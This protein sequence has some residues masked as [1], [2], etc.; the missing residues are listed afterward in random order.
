[1]TTAKLRLVVFTGGPLAP[2]NRVF[3]E[4]LA[5]DPLFDLAAIV[6]DEYRRPLKPLL[7]RIERA[8][9]EDGPAWLAFKLGS[10]LRS[11]SDRATLRIAALA[12]GRPHSEESY[13]T[14]E[15][16]TGV[17]IHRVADIHDAESLELIRSLS[18]K[19]GVIVGGRILRDSV[20]TIP[21]HGTLNIH[22]RKVPDYR[23]GGPVGY[24]ELLAGERFIGVTIHYA[25]T[26]V[27]AGPVLA[28]VTIPIEE[29]DTLESLQLKAD[30]RGA[31]LYHETLRRFAE[32]YREGVPQ[33]LSRGTTYRAPSEFKVWQLRRR[34]ERR[35][36]RTMEVLRAR[37]SRLVRMRVLAQYAVVLPRL[38]AVRRRLVREQRAPINILFYHLV[39]DRPLNHMSLPLPV[40]VRQM[41][42]LWRYYTVLSLDEA[43]ER[44]RSG[45]NDQI[46]ASITF[47]DGYRD[48]A[49]AIEYLRYFG[50]P[51]TFFV[52]IGH[53]RDGSVFE[54][55]RQKGFEEARP[56]SEDDLRSLAGDG[57]VIGSHGVHHE[58]FGSLEPATAEQILRES[59][60]LIQEICGKAP[61]HFSFPKGQR[62]TNIT[63]ASFA[64][65]L[66]YFPYVYSAYSGYCF[67]QNG[68]RHFL[69]TGNPPDVSGLAMLMSGYTGLR[70]CLAGNAWGLKTEELDPCSGTAD[71]QAP[72]LRPV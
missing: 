19:L 40:F 31:Q 35:A 2:I 13:E 1:M 54:H 71:R 24:W 50:I 34:L 52:S 33:D 48:N 55:D 56:M 63:E 47:D 4:R 61:G 68:R 30:L 28:E 25:A 42:F 51:A 23:G 58:D 10:K 6:V 45:K 22:K 32:G 70:R 57:F 8:L 17:R 16:R 72:A 11:I 49:W 36:A 27:D 66:K 14:L 15:A 3:L 53:V 37:P 26:D 5:N 18:P 29:C 67:P 7:T 44:L 41:E 65:A 38:L 46:A 9:R 20:I 62:G 64:L 69:R 43:V 60:E 39:A 59:R 21:T 12:H